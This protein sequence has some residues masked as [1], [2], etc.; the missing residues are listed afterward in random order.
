MAPTNLNRRCKKKNNATGNRC[1]NPARAGHD[2]CSFHLNRH[3]HKTKAGKHH[4]NFKHGM[5]TQDA[6]AAYRKSVIQLNKLEHD[7][8]EAGLIKGPRR[9]GRK[10]NQDG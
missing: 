9:R 3:K 2:L 4:P 6:I 10:P 8:R 1:L 7:A 5:R